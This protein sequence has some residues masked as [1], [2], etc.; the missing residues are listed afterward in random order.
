MSLLAAKSFSQNGLGLMRMT[1]HD[2]PMPDE[3]AFAVLKAALAAGVNVWNGADF[4]GTSEHNS[5]HL[6]ARYF[7]KYP[8]DAEKVVI[9]IKSGI[10]DFRNF[11]MDGS[12]EAVRRSVANANKILGGHKKIDIFGIARVDPKIPIEDTVRALK[13]LVEKGE[14]GGIQLSEVGAATIRRAASVAKIDMVEEEVSLWATDIFD[15][16]VATTCAELGIPIVAHTPLG[17]GMLTGQIKSIDD[18]PPGPYPRIFPRF[19][20]ENFHKNLDLV[21][22][23][24][25]L[26]KAKSVSPAQLALSWLKLQSKKP[27]MPLIIPIAGARSEARVKEN[28]TTVDLS[29]EDLKTITAILDSFPVAG[30][31][32]PAAA[33]KLVEF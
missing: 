12:P 33:M 18:L 21:A 4:Y 5:L 13:E 22:E 8:E 1:S 10:A 7:S 23:I 31:R 25:K 2:G 17:A 28:A 32:Y 19:Q 15:N 29:E 24:E 20:P 9:C 30:D 6:L 27:G 26:A 3:E 11:L 14:I 16:G